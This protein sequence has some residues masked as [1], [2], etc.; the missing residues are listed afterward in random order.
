[1]AIK[2]LEEAANLLEIVVKKYSKKGGNEGGEK[3]MDNAILPVYYLIGECYI[4]MDKVKKAKD[5]LIAAYW[6]S[7][8]STSKDNKENNNILE[9]DEI[10][11]LYRHRAFCLL[12]K[13][14]VS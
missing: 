8:K 1:M 6:S 13:T 5:F 3:I 10:T 2:Q 4:K 14:E 9:E 11:S 12:F 7:L